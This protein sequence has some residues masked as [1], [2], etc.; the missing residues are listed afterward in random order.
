MPM[1]VSVVKT[2]VSLSGCEN[3]QHFSS[4]SVVSHVLPG[5]RELQGVAGLTQVWDPE[6]LEPPRLAAQQPLM[7]EK[8]TA[9][10]LLFGIL[11]KIAKMSSFH[12]S[13]CLCQYTLHLFSSA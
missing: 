13:F 5:H 11:I 10:T 12:S 8:A 1:S 3:W 9:C 4:F 7:A 2:K 6:A